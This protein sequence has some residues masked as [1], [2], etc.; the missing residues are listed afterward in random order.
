MLNFGDE[1]SLGQWVIPRRDVPGVW[2]NPVVDVPFERHDA[3]G[4][5]QKQQ[6]QGR[7]ESKT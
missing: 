1:I 4:Q 5:T 7:C 2:V 6:E 3:A